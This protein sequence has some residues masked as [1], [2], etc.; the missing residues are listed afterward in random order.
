[1]HQLVL[2]EIIFNAE[3]LQANTALIR[4]FFQGRMTDLAVSQHSLVGERISPGEL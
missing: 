2:L 1:M 4:G 3:A